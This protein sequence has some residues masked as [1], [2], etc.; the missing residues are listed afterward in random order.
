M[1]TLIDNLLAFFQ[2]HPA[3]ALEDLL[4]GATDHA[5]VENR[6]REW[7]IRARAAQLNLP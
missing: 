2:P 5:D 3:D 4:A 1:S 7:E 6:L